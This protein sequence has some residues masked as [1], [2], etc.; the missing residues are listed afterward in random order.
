MISTNHIKC[1]YQLK[2]T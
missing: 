1:W 2:M